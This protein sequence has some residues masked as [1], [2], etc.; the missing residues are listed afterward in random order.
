MATTQTG[1]LQRISEIAQAA[2]RHG[3]GYLIDRGRLRELVPWPR[4]VEDEPTMRGT[5]G[6]RLR[7]MLDELGPSFV[8][9]GQLL[10]THPEIVPPDIV[11]ELRTLQD[12]ASPVPYEDISQV[13]IEE[14]G[15]PP[16]EM[17]TSFDSEPIASASIGQVHMATL[18]NG[19][20]VAVKVQRPGAEA[21]VEADI[22]LF[23]QVARLLKEYVRRLDFIDAVELVDEFARSIRAELDYR[24]EA[25]NARLLRS[26]FDGHEGV[27][28]PRVYWTYSTQRVLTLEYVPGPTLKDASDRLTP[29]ER[30]ALA[31][32][33]A[34]VWMEMIFEHGQFHADPHPAN[35]LVLEDGRLGLVDFG[36]IGRLSTED[37]RRVTRLFIDVVSGNLDQMPRR[38]ADL[39]VRIPTA[40]A[41]DLR[42]DLETLWAR[43]ADVELG[44]LDPAE[45]LREVLGLINRYGLT[46]PSRFLLLDRTLITLGGVGQDL[47]PAFNVFEVARPYA[48]ELAMH[49]YSPGV[50]LGRA[51]QEVA[52]S[53]RAILDLPRDVGALV[54]QASRGDMEVGA[55]IGG[56]EEPVRRIDAALN[57][58]G[59]ALVVAGGV[60]GSA[61]VSH[62]PG[63]PHLFGMQIFGLLGFAASAVLGVLLALAAFRR[64]GL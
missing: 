26:A 62:I 23:Y 19:D 9:F 30:Q 44:D 33:I 38:L 46:L 42:A 22:A 48:T 32:Q 5:R 35:I 58:L 24:G 18:P 6:Q 64:G 39:G 40:V 25:R 11:V 54:E 21:T 52:L 59:L 50:L 61:V 27:V 12:H 2:T 29:G 31:Y 7:E 28:I 20:Q 13:L 45:L 49:Q 8:K 51:R 41:D 37:M 3:F 47:Y 15:E 53:T 63:G 16:D 14:L 43:Y 60:I 1:N 10:S 4:R 55:R 34:E 17:F 56:L 57:R 36:I